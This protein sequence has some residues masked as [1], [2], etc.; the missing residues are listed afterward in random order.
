MG[1]DSE[2]G[3]LCVRF[4]VEQLVD[5]DIEV[6][7]AGQTGQV[8]SS[9]DISDIEAVELEII[10]ENIKV[11]DSREE[12]EKLPNLRAI[13]NKKLLEEVREVEKVLSRFNTRG[14]TKTNDFFYPGAIVEESQYGK[15]D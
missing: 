11:L 1:M 13:P 15:G 3:S 12:N 4:F 10:E 14:I 5:S 2:E 8:G 6:D 9:S 7:E